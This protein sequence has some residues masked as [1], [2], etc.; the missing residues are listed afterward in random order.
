M[1]RVSENSSTQ[2]IQ[3]ALK[4]T[5]GKLENLQLKGSI[6]KDI[7]R[8]SD[9][10]IGNVESLNITSKLND[11]V[12]YRKNADYALLNLGGAEKSLSQ[13]VEILNKAKEIAIAQASDF[14]DSNIRGNVANE[15]VQLK[16]QALSI[17]NKR[18]GQRFVFSG[19]KSLTK[20]FDFQGKYHGDKGNITL[21]VSKDF[22]VPISLNGDEVFYSSEDTSNRE[23]DPLESFDEIKQFD[24]PVPDDKEIQEAEEK[25][26]N[27]D[28]A[29]EEIP[30]LEKGFDNRDSLFA[31]LDTLVS[32]LENND[33]PL[34]RELLPRFDKSLTRLITMQ[35]R[36]GSVTNSV[37]SS[38]TNLDSNSVDM[39]TR[40]SYIVDSD[41]AELFSDITRQKNI[42]DATYKSSQGL[43]NNSLLNFLR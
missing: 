37:L 22:F 14:Y 25:K 26:I 28:L 2:S 8:P 21:E 3:F 20:P 41:V 39:A 7:T 23:I 36:I 31:Q 5:K 42:L 6:L 18:I 30:D 24:P 12:Q 32:A 35:T 16:K 34:I 17:A 15:V 38:K 9:N 4:K 10:P 19:F 43:M 1:T 40:K 33:A 13:L 29:S 27:R 11:N